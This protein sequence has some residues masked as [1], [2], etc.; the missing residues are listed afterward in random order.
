[1]FLGL[2]TKD[3]DLYHSHEKFKGHLCLIIAKI[4]KQVLSEKQI[5]A[6]SLAHYC[7]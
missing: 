4:L 6:D 2:K 7:T 3:S 5:V 1:M